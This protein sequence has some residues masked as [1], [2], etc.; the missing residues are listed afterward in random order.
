MKVESLCIDSGK[1][2][3]HRDVLEV[4]YTLVDTTSSGG[5]IPLRILKGKQI[6]PQALC[7]W[8][9]NSLETGAFPDPLKVAEIAPIHKKKG[10]FD[11]DSYRPMV[12]YRCIKSL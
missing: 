11:K 8:I 4:I 6:F 2:V 5:D 3:I 1:L 10:P 7:K 12:F 9:N